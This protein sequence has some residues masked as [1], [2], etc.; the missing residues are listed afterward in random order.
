MKLG[1]G[2][3][4]NSRKSKQVAKKVDWQKKSPTYSAVAQIKKTLT[5]E[6][7]LESCFR[8]ERF[9]FFFAIDRKSQSVLF[10]FFLF[11]Y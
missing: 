5:T 10:L 3:Q 8:L 4:L 11:G 1:E 6:L 2:E 9:F 7:C